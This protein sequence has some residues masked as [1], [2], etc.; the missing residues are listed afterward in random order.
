M[1]KKRKGE[2]GYVR[3][4]KVVRLIRTIALFVLA[5][6]ILIIGLILNDGD[7]KNIYTVIAM[8]GCVPACM[9]LVSAIMMWLRRPMQASLYKDIQEHADGLYMLYELY[10]TTREISLFLDAAAVSG[11]YVMA[12]TSEKN[13]KASD[14]RY[15]EE[16]I[17]KTVRQ[18]GEQVMVKIFTQ[19][20]AFLERLDTLRAKAD[21]KEV[22]D[23]REWRI[24][25]V[26]KAVSL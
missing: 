10:M 24:G 25:E 5:F 2:Y 22:P 14:I 19:E 8:V 21:E 26:M 20:K 12:Y 23:D 1:K 11:D 18:D 17:T 15:M 6:A 13:R 4:Q 3:S 9:S 7:R 16:H